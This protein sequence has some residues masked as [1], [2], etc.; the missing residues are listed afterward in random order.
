M[1]RAIRM[2]AFMAFSFP[3]GG[4]DDAPACSIFLS[5]AVGRDFRTDF[6][7]ARVANYRSRVSES[8]PRCGSA[9]IALRVRVAQTRIAVKRGSLSRR[10]PGI[11]ELAMSCPERLEHMRSNSRVGAY[12]G[13]PRKSDVPDLRTVNGPISGKPDIDVHFS[14]ICASVSAKSLCSDFA[15]PPPPRNRRRNRCP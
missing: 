7:A 14:G 4:G 15:S 11:R 2:G 3:V 6:F 10:A 5:P 13:K 9:G 12:P 1:D 8:V